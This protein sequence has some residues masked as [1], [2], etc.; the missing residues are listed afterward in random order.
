MTTA[1][2]HT[3]DVRCQNCWPHQIQYVPY[4]PYVVPVTFYPDTE[5]RVQDLE[6]EVERLKKLVEDNHNAE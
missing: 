5:K 1:C 4:H 2:Y 6:R 3:G